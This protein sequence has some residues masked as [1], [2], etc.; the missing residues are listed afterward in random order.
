MN[1][2][3]QNQQTE[4]NE[5]GG[6]VKMEKKEQREGGVMCGV[7]LCCSWSQAMLFQLS[8]TRKGKRK[9]KREVG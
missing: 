8:I 6:A 3:T 9:Q 1:V 5:E 7:L 4:G 2:T